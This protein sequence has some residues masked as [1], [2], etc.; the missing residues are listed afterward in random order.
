[1]MGMIRT[2]KGTLL[3]CSMICY[4]DARCH[5]FK[6]YTLSSGEVCHLYDYYPL[7]QDSLVVEEYYLLHCV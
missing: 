2:V 1:M 6:S 7:P 4:I 5:G 3:E